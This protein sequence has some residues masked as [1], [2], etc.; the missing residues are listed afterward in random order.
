MTEGSDNFSKEEK[1]KAENDFLKMK[2]MLE[3]GAAFNINGNK[4]L[5]AEIENEF[6]NNIIAFGKQFEEH[7]T[8]KLFDKIGKPLHFKQVNEIPDSDID[9]AWNELN[10]YLN[11]YGIDLG[12]CSPGITNRE[13]YRFTTEELFDH[14][15]DD[16]NLP[17]WTISFI[18]DEFHPDPV[19]DNSR[20]VEQNL[21]HDI[22]GKIDLFYKLDYDKD[23]FVFNNKP[24]EKSEPFF[25]MINQ[26]K[27]LFDEIEL[28]GYT[29]SNCV[30]QDTDCIVKGN[31]QAI[32][33]NRDEI[34]V[35]KGKY[36]VELVLKET[37]HWY[38]KNI[39]I[40]GFCLA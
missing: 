5:P 27:S 12:V 39:Q 36:T 32:A 4:E 21:F 9:K 29:T 17:G 10:D 30:V 20:M 13:L 1:L 11:K 16:M 24:Y 38:F 33:K 26:F 15:M 37:G 14:E 19:Y 7:K 2:L 23:G 34:I 35:Y 6:L 31:Y 3:R 18:Y 40:D 22:F 28:A 8:I 25:K